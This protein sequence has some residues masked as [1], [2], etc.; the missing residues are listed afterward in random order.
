ML[1]GD[2]VPTPAELNRHV[3]LK[4]SA[5]WEK[6]GIAL[7]LDQHR[8]DIISKDNAYNPHRSEA[9]CREM[10]ERWLQINTS[11]TWGILEHAVHAI[12]ISDDPTSSVSCDTIGT[13]VIITLLIN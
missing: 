13:M 10:L 5:V 8:L 6:L 4:F 12:M 7:G 2:D 9:C 11:A 1:I 3:V